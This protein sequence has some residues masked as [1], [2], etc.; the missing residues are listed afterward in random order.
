VSERQERDRLRE[1][2]TGSAAAVALVALVA[3]VPL[4]LSAAVGW[5]LPHHLP[6]LSGL[7]TSLTS[8][9]IPNRT[10]L[11]ILACVAWVAWA[12]VVL[13]IIEET[14]ATLR[15][16]SAKRIPL[17]STFQPLAAQLVAA[18]LLAA[19]TFGRTQPTATAPAR[20]PLAEHLYPASTASSGYVVPTSPDPPTQAPPAPSG[21][22]QPAARTYTVE[23]NDTLWAIAQ[24][25][26]GNPLEWREIFALNEGRPQPDGRALT[27]PHWIYPGWQLILPAA[28]STP[29]PNP[30]TPQSP[31]PAAS[32]PPVT[33]TTVPSVTPPLSP[34]SAPRADKSPIRH[35]NG[36]AQRPIVGSPSNDPIAIPSDSL[37]AS[38]FAAGVLTAMTIGRLRRRRRYQPSDPEPGRDLHPP[39]I[40][41]TLRN[42]RAAH[43]ERTQRDGDV[44][45][46]VA[47]SVFRTPR[48]RLT[49]AEPKASEHGRLGL[50]EV[51]TR[52]DGPVLLDLTKPGAV[53]LVGP[54][55][56]DVVR[57]WCAA[58]MTATE[59]GSCEL[60]TTES[61]ANSLFPQL[62]PTTMIRAMSNPETLFRNVE[63]EILTRTRT[64]FEAELA[65][66]AAY[67]KARPEDPLPLVLVIIDEVP[68]ALRGRWRRIVEATPRLG[69]GF[70]TLGIEEAATAQIA[71]DASRR[72]S[73]AS[74][75]ELQEKLYD[76]TLF[77]LEG[78]E[79]TE[80]LRTVA[81]AQE[82]GFD[83]IRR[84]SV[85][86]NLT[87]RPIERSADG[88]P[89]EDALSDQM[90]AK[91]I[92]VRLLGPYQ[93]TAHGEEVTKGLRSA[94]KELLAWYLLRPEGAS[95]EAAVDALWPD[96]ETDLVTK[97][98]WRALGDL[99]TRLRHSDSSEKQELL[100][101]S[102]NH[103][104]PKSDEITCDLWD[105][106]HYLAVAAR[107][108]DDK[109]TRSA[110]RAAIDLYQ[111]DFVS[112]LDYL[113]AEPVRE[114]LHRRALDAHI[115]LAE[116]EEAQSHESAAIDILMHA[117]KLD[118]YAE[119]IYRRLMVLQSRIGRS[120]SISA[121][122]RQLQRSLADLDLDP[123]Q[124]TTRIY[125]ELIRKHA[126]TTA[127]S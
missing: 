99:R 63:A 35:L 8:R 86:A 101:R 49:I 6:G 122:W 92:G 38:S 41:P 30:P 19:L 84:D 105:F 90:S 61:T 62:A 13:S 69:I 107:A 118:R 27:D 111:G 33:P 120:D 108:D 65:N 81:R 94:G 60:L 57:A 66:A 26:L 50:I 9:G 16:R 77:G 24:N 7:R 123:A 71:T 20:G 46:D 117:I 73:A 39:P 124:P 126:T 56:L 80:L 47:P 5:P 82:E 76:S 21:A 22:E 98:F 125:Q 93:I 23:P 18:V 91:S 34:L 109:E 44:Q 52:D 102:G 88:W 68:E 48:A 121:T 55:V 112:D 31:P 79:A 11:D 32:V 10:L 17:A 70:L 14:R 78:L 15:G 37:V 113:W 95:L 43:S 58:L 72:V 100:I 114:D 67:R 85:R 87:D 36:L 116:L 28:Q 59:H 51:G 89:D 115:H 127:D 104:H 54:N 3:G 2:A 45:R 4:A 29:I 106:E 25:Q 40:A 83:D 53:D 74:P 110:L 103:Y 119:E 12:S 96:T 75:E 64:L 1:L 42:L 97:R